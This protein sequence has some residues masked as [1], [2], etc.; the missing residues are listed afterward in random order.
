MGVVVDEF[1]KSISVSEL[2]ELQLAQRR[3]KIMR[4]FF[5]DAFNIVLS[6]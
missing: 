1:D 5:N 6:Y 4:F 2:S 3:N